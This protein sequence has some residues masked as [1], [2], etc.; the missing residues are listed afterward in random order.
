MINPTHF[1]FQ[2]LRTFLVVAQT[3]SPSKV[4]D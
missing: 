4:P 1:N 3:G 2:L